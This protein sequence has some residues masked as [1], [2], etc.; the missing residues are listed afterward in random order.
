MIKTVSLASLT[1]I[2]AAGAAPALAQSPDWS[3]PYVGIYGSYIEPADGENESLTFDRNLDGRFNDTVVTASGDNAFSA[4][5]C[6]GQA[7]SVS[8]AAGCHGDK[9]GVEAGIRAGYDYQFGSFVV[10]GLVELSGTEVQD[11]VTSFSTTP[12]AYVF[13]RNLENLAA[14]RG[15]FWSNR[16]DVGCGCGTTAPG[17]PTR[18]S[19]VRGHNARAR[20]QS[21]T[22][23]RSA[24]S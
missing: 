13:K 18:S 21:F 19:T 11:T 23:L 15:A 8:A 5:S 22:Q 17:L 12:A 20:R 1:L 3:G 4:G 2:L 6:S 14:A 16:N 10:G 7:N 9:G 24:L